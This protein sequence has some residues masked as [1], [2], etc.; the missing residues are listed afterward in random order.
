MKNSEN[1]NDRYKNQLNKS[2]SGV[3]IELNEVSASWRINHPLQILN[4]ITLK[5]KSGELCAVVGPAGSGKSS[6]LNLLLQELPVDAGTV[7]LFQMKN[8]VPVNLRTTLGFVQSKP[9]ITISYA[10]QDPLLFSGT[11]KDNILFGLEYDQARYQEVCFL[12]KDFKDLPNRDMTIVG[13]GG[14]PL[15]IDLKTKINLARTIYRQADLYLLDDIFHGIDDNDSQ[16]IFNE[17]V[18]GFLQ[19]K[20][21]ILVTDHIDYLKQADTIAVIEK[22][23]ISEKMVRSNESHVGQVGALAQKKR[24][25]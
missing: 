2:S 4:S 25:T 11:I 5:F 6:L 24:F 10:S 15:S 20:T 19:G 12:V 22:V 23:R 17:C 16:F 21:R 7:R 1:E 13:E 8:G 14:K 9:E 3:E 18:L